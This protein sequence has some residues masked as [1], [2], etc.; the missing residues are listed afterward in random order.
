M[1]RINKIL[2][3]K[4]YLE[5]LHK[6]ELL[7]KDRI[8]CKHNITHFLDVCRI[9]WILNL[10]KDRKLDKELVYAAGLLHDI[11]RWKQ[12]ESGEDH[13]KVSEILCE[14]I[15]ISCDFIKE[16]ILQIKEAIGNH[17]KLVS[18]SELSEILY[19][20]DKL[21]RNCFSCVAIGECKNFKTGEK[22]EL[23]Y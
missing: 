5:H 1:D 13:A 8:F 22:G 6:I 7:E 3:D 21:S 15:L 10:E 20:S 19:K 16:E 4:G 23:F 9:A 2:Q 17:R 18:S 11:G 12:Y 14:E